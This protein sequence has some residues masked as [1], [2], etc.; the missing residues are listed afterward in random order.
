MCEERYKV[1]VFYQK[2]AQ[3]ASW[4]ARAQHVIGIAHSIY[5]GPQIHQV[6][7]E[8]YARMARLAAEVDCDWEPLYA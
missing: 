8:K 1:A 3:E 6:K 7:A 5:T 4:H 2:K